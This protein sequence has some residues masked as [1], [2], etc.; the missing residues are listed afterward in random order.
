MGWDRQ[1]SEVMQV[2]VRPVIT[3]WALSA[4]VAGLFAVLLF[5]L[6]VSERAPALHG[7][8]VW[9]FSVSPLLV[10]GL[11]FATCAYRYGNALA[12]FEFLEE[13]AVVA[14]QSWQDWAHRSLAVHASCVLLPDQVCAGALVQDAGQLPARTGQAR[15]I[16]ALPAPAEQR[17]RAGLQ[18]LFSALAPVLQALPQAQELRVTLLTDAR[19]EQFA[20]LRDAWVQQWADVTSRPPPATINVTGE[21]AFSWVEQ[22]LKAARS[23]FELIVVLQVHGQAVYSDGI[24]ML[25]LCP[26]NLASAWKLPVKGTLLRPMP[27]QIDQLQRELPLFL[28]TQVSARHATGL[29]VNSVGLKTSMGEILGVANAQKTSLDA[30]CQWVQESLS[31][32]P[33]PFGHWLVVAFGAEVSQVRQQ[34]LLLVVKDGSQ[35]WISTVIPGEFA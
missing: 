18:L 9:V 7:L 23:A 1:S 10:W 29:L 26:D 32:V 6:Y 25:V 31:G 3:R 22:T 20:Q 27:L 11:A 15:R 4:V 35:H 8:N 17:A 34:P 19:P 13:E 21:C 24:A 12:R 33:G 5:L 2:P 28:Q 16:A 14:Q 30:R